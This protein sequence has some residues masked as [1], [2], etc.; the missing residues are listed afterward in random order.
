MMKIDEILEQWS[1]DSS[2][3]N[4]Q[5]ESEIRNIPKLH[6]KYLKIYNDHKLASVRTKYEFEKMKSIKEKYYLGHLDEETLKEYGWEPFDIRI[7]TKSGIDRY[8]DS[9]DQLIKIL[10]KKSYYEEGV[11]VCEKILNEIK[12][13]TWQLK[14]Y[15]DYI[16]FEAG[17]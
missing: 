17:G 9:D 2:I 4:T 1:I 14:M 10:T 7:G 8:I 13:R 5:V 11:D 6:A 3:D 16:R 12:N 15:V